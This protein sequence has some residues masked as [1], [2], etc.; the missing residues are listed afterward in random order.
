MSASPT[1]H[2][3]TDIQ[4]YRRVR[5]TKMRKCENGALFPN[6]YPTES[7]SGVQTSPPAPA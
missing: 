2:N 1:Y 3:A 5:Y 7:R 4:T 6:P